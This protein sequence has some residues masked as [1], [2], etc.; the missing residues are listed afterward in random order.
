MRL[1][2][3]RGEFAQVL[4]VRLKCSHKGPAKGE[5]GRSGETVGDVQ[6]GTGVRDMRP[7][8][9]RPSLQDH[10]SLRDSVALAGSRVWGCPILLLTSP[11]GR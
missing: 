2:I 8:T 10:R 6:G 3:L 5:A 1:W 4:R 9:W 7:E 11:G